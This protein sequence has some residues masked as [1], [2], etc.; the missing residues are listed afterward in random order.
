[1]VVT[2]VAWGRELTHF[3]AQHQTIPARTMTRS[4]AYVVV[5]APLFAQLTFTLFYG[6]VDVFGGRRHFCCLTLFFRSS[7]SR[8]RGSSG[9]SSSGSSGWR[10]VQVSGTCRQC[11]DLPHARFGTPCPHTQRKLCLCLQIANEFCDIRDTLYSTRSSTTA[12]R[13]QARS[14]P[15]PKPFL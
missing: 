3:N 8:K 7:E 1:M 4:A 12:T 11:K 13:F 14:A 6:E 5:T 2:N 9:S 10:D 15:A